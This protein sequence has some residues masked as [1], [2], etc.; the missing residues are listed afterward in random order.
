MDWI[1]LHFSQWHTCFMCKHLKV[2]GHYMQAGKLIA[3][4]KCLLNTDMNIG[5][6]QLY[7]TYPM[8]GYQLW[9]WILSIVTENTYT[10]TGFYATIY[11]VYITLSFRLSNLS[12]LWVRFPVGAKTNGRQTKK[13]MWCHA[14]NFFFISKNFRGTKS[15]L[16]GFYPTFPTLTSDL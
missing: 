3:L 15:V 8:N 2:V 9:I 12:L 11:A 1:S 7:K 16:T 14:D 5:L 10:C 13:R 4:T 6:S